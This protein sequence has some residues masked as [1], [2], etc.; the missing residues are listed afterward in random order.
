MKKSLLNMLGNRLTAVPPAELGTS[1]F[2]SILPGGRVVRLD[3]LP[4]LN[5]SNSGHGH[6]RGFVCPPDQDSGFPPRAGD[7]NMQLVSLNDSSIA[8]TR[9]AVEA[10]QSA[11]MDKI[12]HSPVA[13]KLYQNPKEEQK[14]GEGPTLV[15]QAQME[16]QEEQQEEEENAG[17]SGPR[18]I[19]RKKRPSKS[20]RSDPSR[21]RCSK[22]WTCLSSAAIKKTSNK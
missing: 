21:S 8:A 20:D 3:I 22:G 9:R 19:G 7:E 14:P 18:R 6:G 10:I 17:R 16:P 15:A 4:Q 12:P 1:S 2:Q 5:R 11:D 13:T